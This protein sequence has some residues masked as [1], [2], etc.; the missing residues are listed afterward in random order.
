MVNKRKL[1]VVDDA[2]ENIQPLIST[3]KDDF[4]IQVAK[5]GND[6]IKHATE[7]PQPDIILLDIMMPDM[8]GYQVCKY[9]KADDRTKDIPIIFVTALDSS[10][11]EEKGL[12]LGAVDYI[13]KPINPQL[14]KARVNN[15]LELKLYRDHLKHELDEKEE[16]LM[17]QSRHAAMGEMIGIIA[18]Q[19]RQPIT[20]ISLEASNMIASIELETANLEEL[21]KN[22]K[23]IIDQT[24]YISKTI[25]D[26]RNFFRPNKE[27]T[28]VK[29]EDILVDTKK[30]LGPNLDTYGIQLITEVKDSKPI[31]CYPREL[32]HVYIN[33]LK[34]AKDVF[35]E[36]ETK[37]RKV[38]VTIDSD[39]NGIISTVCDNGGGIDDSIKDKL[40]DIYFS[41]KSGDNG[42]GLGLYISKIILEKHLNGSISV[43]NNDEGACFTIRIPFEGNE[44]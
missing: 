30:I 25:D 11:D 43:E 13:T 42:L 24:I 31:M 10:E 34:N 37:Q 36:K 8:D 26:F 7:E 41:T 12:K 39:E 38:T 44:V 27:K 17:V 14:V 16:I 21:K 6:A 35:I 3:L 5:N 18:H 9:L 19:W 1:L 33:L 23:D 22:S 28:V 2:P 40:F 32:V 4:A 29:L 15:H 20:T